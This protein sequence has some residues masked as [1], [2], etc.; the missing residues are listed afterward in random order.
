[1]IVE[2]AIALILI[3]GVLVLCHELGHF[4]TAK[5]VGIRVEELAFGFG[6][7][8]LTLFRRNETDYTIRLVP[9]GGFVRLAGMEPGQEDVPDGFQA[10]PISRR[11]LVVFAG[12]L[13]SFLLAV[14]AFLFV[15]VYWGFPDLS[16]PEAR[17]GQVNPKTEAARIGLRA[18]DRILQIDGD[19]IKRGRQMID[20]I[21]RRPG[22]KVRLLV[23]RRGSRFV[24][25]GTP[26]WNV[27]YL[28]ATWSF[29]L[30]ERA[31]VENLGEHSAARRAGIMPND[32]LLSIDGRRILSGPDMVRAV[33]A[34]ANQEV[35]LELLRAGKHVTVKA[36]P[37]I[38][39]VSLAGARWGFPGGVAESGDGAIRSTT[40]AGRAGVR[41]G[42]WIHSI[43]GV[44]IKTGEQ[45]LDIIRSSRSKG[46]SP[47]IAVKR[48]GLEEPIRFRPTPE[49]IAAMRFGYYDTVGLLGFLPAPTLV[50]AGFG[51][52]VARGLRE[53]GQRVAYLVRVL[54]SKQIAS[55]VGGPVMIA[56]ATAS[57]VALGPYY[58]VDMAG[59]LSLSLA[60]INLIP[61][62]I[63]D[64]GLIAILIIEA[65]R[66]KRLTPQQAQAVALVGFT[67]VLL[68]A[69]LIVYLDIFRITEGLV[70]Q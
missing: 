66:R 33:R 12:P 34:K 30:R 60:F 28:G 39:W 22:R 7:R 27:M 42:D 61:I 31:L 36:K 47:E 29:M 1:M 63:L 9:A 49:D 10:Q 21:H 26:Q 23:E 53:F 57:S 48:E 24:K 64:G 14:V 55:D 52:S 38:Q 67:T 58:V 62:P 59:M 16:L 50:R 51:E 56:R 8:L 43:N 32:V 46:R 6:P 4:A 25:V 65:I 45:M 2:T 18:G 20:Y 69:V 3:F 19:E 40:T 11:M 44:E 70:P 5:L 68:L 13:M 37:D 15:G 17:V 35:A 54:T 41:Q